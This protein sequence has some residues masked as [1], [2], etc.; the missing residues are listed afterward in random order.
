MRRH[1]AGRR[2][3][4]VLETSAQI[5]RL[6]SAAADPYGLATLAREQLARQRLHAPAAEELAMRKA[7]QR[8]RREAD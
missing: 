7:E 3:S 6:D 8:G 5:A 1:A 4:A 2:W